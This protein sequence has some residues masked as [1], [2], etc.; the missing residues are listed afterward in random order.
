MQV[1][2]HFSWLHEIAIPV[3]FTLLG[4]GI[5]YF[6]GALR[7]GQKAKRDKIAFLRAIGMEL[8]A[9]GAQLDSSSLEVTGSKGRLEDRTSQG[10]HFAFALRTSVFESQIGKLRDVDDPLLIKIVHFYSDT[11]TLEHIFESANDTGAEY[12]RGDRDSVRPRLMSTLI[13]LQNQISIFSKRL[14]ELR[15]ELPK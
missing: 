6:A 14:R 2:P 9:L 13:E 7:D 12:A 8:D 11:G 5:G 4:A 15:T 3:C 10:V 1:E